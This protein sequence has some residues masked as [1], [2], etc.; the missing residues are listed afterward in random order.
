MRYFN[1]A[2][3][4]IERLRSDV[5]QQFAAA[6]EVGVNVTYSFGIS[7]TSM[8]SGDMLLERASVA[9]QRAKRRGGNCVAIA[10][11]SPSPRLAA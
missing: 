3:K 6:K 5:E 9:A 8:S 1:A 4:M 2:S 11:T 10:R 7:D